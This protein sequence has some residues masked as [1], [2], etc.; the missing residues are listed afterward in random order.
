VTQKQLEAKSGES[1]PIAGRVAGAGTVSLQ[2]QYGDRKLQGDVSDRGDFL[3]VLDQIVEG[4]QKLTV[5]A[6]DAL[7]REARSEMI[8]IGKKR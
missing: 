7:G 3:I 6:T 2:I 5:I 8:I 4:K 1:I